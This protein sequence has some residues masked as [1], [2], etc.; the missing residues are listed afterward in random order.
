MLS[1]FY[2]LIGRGAHLG[3][4]GQAFD[5][6]PAVFYLTGEAQGLQIGAQFTVYPLLLRG[7]GEGVP[8]S[9]R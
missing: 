3:Q 9:Q 4:P 8:Q 2:H 7:V 5:A 6:Q 1:P